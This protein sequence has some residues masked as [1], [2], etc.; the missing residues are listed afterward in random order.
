LAGKLGF[1]AL[2]LLAMERLLEGMMVGCLK[3]KGKSQFGLDRVRGLVPEEGITRENSGDF[4]WLCFRSKAFVLLFFL[5]GC[6]L[7]GFVCLLVG[8]QFLVGFFEFGSCIDLKVRILL[9][10]VTPG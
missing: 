1:V 9:I 7:V 5:V 2:S 4:G 8:G 6:Q 3:M 10:F